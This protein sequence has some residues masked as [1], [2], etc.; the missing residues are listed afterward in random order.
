MNLCACTQTL[1]GVCEGPGSV[2]L[3]SHT[4]PGWTNEIWEFDCNLTLYCLERRFV[5]LSLQLDISMGICRLKIIFI[6]ISASCYSSSPPLIIFCSS[7]QI[8]CQI[9]TEYGQKVADV[10]SCSHTVAS[11][12]FA[13]SVTGFINFI[14]SFW[15]RGK[16][17]TAAVRS[18]K[19]HRSVQVQ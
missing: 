2:A 9:Y 4:G 5:F 14:M 16:L 8:M 18:V 11:T 12:A 17:F 10:L 7:I 1:V 19:V 15:K 3:S 6:I 13:M